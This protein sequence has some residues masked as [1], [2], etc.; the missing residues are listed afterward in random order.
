MTSLS[1][2]G[3]EIH[4]RHRLAVILPI[5]V[6]LFAIS[7]TSSYLL[8]FEFSMTSS[9]WSSMLAA[10]PLFV[11]AKLFAFS[12]L[13]EWDRTFRYA[14]INDAF[15][16]AICCTIGAIGMLAWCADPSAL[17][18][19]SHATLAAPARLRAAHGYGICNAVPSTFRAWRW[20]QCC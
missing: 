5:Y 9:L 2:A 14:T 4:M 20:R 16:T 3:P 1:I 15:V 13:R 19:P 18:A 12:T 7:L 17:R 6:A 11:A 10:L 8:R